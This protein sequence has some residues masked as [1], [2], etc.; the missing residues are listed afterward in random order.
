MHRHHVIPRH[1]GGLDIEENIILLTREEHADAHQKLYEANGDDAD[2]RAAILIEN[3]YYAGCKIIQKEWC[4]QGA[5]AA[6]EKKSQNG[7]YEK[8]GKMNSERLTGSPGQEKQMTAMVE[9]VKGSNWWNNG[10][11]NI[12]SKECPGDGYVKG[13]TEYI[14][15]DVKQRLSD[16]MKT[17]RWY[18]NGER[19]MRS[20]IHPGD[21]WCLGRIKKE[22]NNV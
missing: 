20:E 13:R 21:G 12:R 16:A 9:S 17:K 14:T 4:Q 5:K 6:H 8:L 2:R 1:A 10:C 22:K 11:T 3:G 7:F 15:D 18:N 19:N